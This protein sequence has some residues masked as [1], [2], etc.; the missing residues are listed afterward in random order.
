M[1]RIRRSRRN[2]SDTIGF[3]SDSDAGDRRLPGGILLAI[4]RA[5]VAQIHGGRAAV[6]AAADVALSSGQSSSDG[7]INSD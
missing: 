3:G 6:F 7:L 5:R 1:E 2:R 4:A